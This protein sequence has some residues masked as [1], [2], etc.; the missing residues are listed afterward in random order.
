MIFFF[1]AWPD[2]AWEN[3]RTLGNFSLGFLWAQANTNPIEF[4]RH[5]DQPQYV[6]YH[7]HGWQLL[8]G[9]A[10]ILAGVALLLIVLWLGFRLRRRPRAA[11]ATAQEQVA[12]A[13]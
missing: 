9:N 1:A 10:Y 2:A 11:E 3:A 5:G 13:L 7:W 6:E 12:A 8:W 4:A